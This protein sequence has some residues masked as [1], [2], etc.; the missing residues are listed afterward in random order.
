MSGRPRGTMITVSA[1]ELS[2]EVLRQ[3]LAYGI[4]ESQ[5]IELLADGTSIGPSADGKG[6]TALGYAAMG[7]NPNFVR[8]IVAAGAEVDLPDARGLTPLMLACCFPIHNKP[9]NPAVVHA[10]IDAGADVGFREARCG[11][12]ALALAASFGKLEAVLAL[13]AAGADLELHDHSGNTALHSAFLSD[14]SACARALLAAGADATRKNADG[15]SALELTEDPELI[16]LIRAAI[17]ARIV[18]VD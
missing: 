3:T 6:R 9:V 15:C 8:L 16:S 13:I 14:Q 2:P 10:L 11:A 1:D 4:N 17:S 18:P 12:A 7:G 5:V